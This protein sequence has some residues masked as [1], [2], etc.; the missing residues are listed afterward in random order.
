VNAATHINGVKE[1]IASSG[2]NATAR[3]CSNA[4]HGKESWY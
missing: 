3:T 2:W 4:C 1:V